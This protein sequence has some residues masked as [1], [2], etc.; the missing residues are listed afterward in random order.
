MTIIPS[1]EKMSDI[2]NKIQ[3]LKNFIDPYQKSFLLGIKK[4]KMLKNL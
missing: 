1:K 4:I 3:D 2:K